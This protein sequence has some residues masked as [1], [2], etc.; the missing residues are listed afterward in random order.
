MAHVDWVAARDLADWLACD[1]LDADGDP[2]L[3]EGYI[4]S[5]ERWK[6]LEESSSEDASAAMPLFRVGLPL[7]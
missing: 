5:L 6:R 4:S 1:H 7:P 3:A 2:A